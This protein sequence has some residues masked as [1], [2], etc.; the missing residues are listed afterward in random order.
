[1][2]KRNSSFLVLYTDDL[3]KTADFY[4]KFGVHIKEQDERKCVF[5]F[6]DF[7]IH[8]NCQEDVP[9][10]KYIYD[11]FRGGGVILY[12]EAENIE[13]IYTIA[14]CIGGILKSEI[15]EQPWGTKEFLFQ[16][17]NGYNIVFY[18]EK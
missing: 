3:Q 16:D 10:Y 12:V 6:G 4:R 15:N 9:E 7:D 17:P 18:E 2:L 1:M 8:F 11:N 13:K 5:G 14:K